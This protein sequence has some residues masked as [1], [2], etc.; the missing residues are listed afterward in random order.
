MISI[1][2]LAAAA[3]ATQHSPQPLRTFG[4]WTM[5]CDNGHACTAM[6]LVPELY[7]GEWDDY[8]QVTLKRRAEA[9][10][11]FSIH[12]DNDPDGPVTLLV[13]GRV[14]AS[15]VTQDMALTPAMVDAMRRGGTLTLRAADGR[16]Y[17]ASLAGITASLLAIDDTQG[18]V[19]TVTA[20]VRRG[21]APMRAAIP[22]LPVIDGPSVAASAAA[23]PRTLSVAAATALIGEV[24]AVCDYS[25]APVDPQAHR[26]DTGHSLV[27]I[28]HPCGN[29]AYNYFTTAMIV[30]ETGSATP[31]RFEVDPGMGEDRGEPGNVI[32]NVSYDAATR[33]ISAY[34]KGRAAGDCNVVTDYIWDGTRFALAAQFRM[35]EC[36]G[37][38]DHIQVWRT[39]VR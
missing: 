13:D 4:D 21:R 17:A 28:N 15:R 12:W 26:L 39:T 6:S 1:L 23:A 29:G 35:D 25:G 8:L 5:G 2:A 31:A 7:Q 3:V 19:G 16:R 27:L 18:R 14:I 10:A 9:D 30:D 37:R 36:R 20:A 24:N 34:A 33:S 38:R 11:P 22:A 32:V